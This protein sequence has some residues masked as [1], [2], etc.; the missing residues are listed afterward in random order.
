MPLLPVCTSLARMKVSEEVR[1]A[2]LWLIAAFVAQVVIVPW[3]YRTYTRQA[4]GLLDPFGEFITTDYAPIFSK[5]HPTATISFRRLLIQLLVTG[6]AGIG[7]LALAEA[8]G[9]PD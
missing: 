8:P 7:W 1:R 4:P 2:V 6:A 9:E 5:P 3:T